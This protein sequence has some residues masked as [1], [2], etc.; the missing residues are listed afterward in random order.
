[1]PWA[2][3]TVAGWKCRLATGATSLV[4]GKHQNYF[5]TGTQDSLWGAPSRTSEPWRIYAAPN[6]AKKLSRKV[7][8]KSAWF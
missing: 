4:D 6:A 8:I 3:E 7:E 5:S 2:L 1:L